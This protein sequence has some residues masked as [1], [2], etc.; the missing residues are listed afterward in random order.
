MIVL[1]S[2]GSIQY[3]LNPLQKVLTS[4]TVTDR[5][6][7]I[8]EYAALLQP[9]EKLRRRAQPE[10]L[11]AH[12]GVVIAVAHVTAH[13]QAEQLAHEVIFQA[14]AGDLPLVVQILRADEADDA[15]DEERVER[16]GDAIGAGL[17]RQL[18]DAVVRLGR[19]SAP[20]A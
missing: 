11:A 13:R 15:V 18:I 16:T 3:C 4:D 10:N 12:G 19:Q 5:Q 1:S 9:S 7:P 20:L 17:E 6:L 14:G 8:A 2:A